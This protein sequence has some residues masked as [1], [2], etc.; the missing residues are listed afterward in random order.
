MTGNTTVRAQSHSSAQIQVSEP[1]QPMAKDAHPAFLVATIKPSD[2]SATGGWAFPNE[3]RHITCINA[4]VATIV[5]VAYGIHI[6]Q[7]ADAPDWL[8]KDRYDIDGVPDA[9]GIPSLQQMQQMYQKLLAERFHLAFRRETRRIPVNAITIAKGGPRLKI[10]EPNEELNTGNS[11]SSGRRILKFTNVSMSDFALN[12]NL[13]DDRPV[14]DQTGLP[15]RYDFT[16]KWTYDISRE[17]DP[18]APPSLFTAI[19]EQLGL[20]MEA[21][22]G[23]AEVFVIDHVEPPSEN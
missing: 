2:P 6:K 21:V 14:I 18:D 20:R 17:S 8:S 7:I 23:P 1:E 4:T 16:L 10:A 5:T 9:P 13:Y 12:M 22:K 3:G 15:G 11:D 19:K